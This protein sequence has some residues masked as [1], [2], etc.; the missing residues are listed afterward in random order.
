MNIV[1]V[2]TGN[3]CRSPMAEAIMTAQQLPG[4]EVRSAGIFAGEAP[5]SDHAH[6]VLDAEGIAFHHL[7]KPL[8]REDMQWATLILTMTESHKSILMSAYP[9]KSDHI[10]TLKEFAADSGG[11]V[12]DPY[13]GSLS[14]YRQTYEELDKLIRRLTEKL[15]RETDIP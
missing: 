15:T 5:M 14:D 12:Q 3:T 8:N 9:E 1:F 7:S 6:T 10:F 4:V 2:C 11:D 13:G